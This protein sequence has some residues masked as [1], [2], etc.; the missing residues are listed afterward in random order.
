MKDIE[1]E[2][3]FVG[4][5]KLV[6]THSTYEIHI[7][8]LQ[9]ALCDINPGSHGGSIPSSDTKFYHHGKE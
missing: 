9:V 8:I 3:A 2:G 4:M 5:V 1:N 6:D 7:S